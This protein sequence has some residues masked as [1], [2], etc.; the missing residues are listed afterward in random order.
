MNQR[1]FDIKGLM[2]YMSIG[3]NSAMKIGKDA[4]AIVRFGRRVLYD[5]EKIDEYIEEKMRH[6]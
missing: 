1:L 4:G 2:Q 3:R 6:E 5:R